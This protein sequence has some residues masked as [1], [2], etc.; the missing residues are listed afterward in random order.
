MRSLVMQIRIPARWHFDNIFATSL[1]G[2][3]Q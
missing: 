1:V 3:L 2:C